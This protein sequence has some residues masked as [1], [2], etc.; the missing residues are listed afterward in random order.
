[1]GRIIS[2]KLIPLYVT[3]LLLGKPL[4]VWQRSRRV[5][6][7]CMSRSCARYQAV[8][9]KVV[10]ETYN[11]GG[12]NEW[13][14]IDV[15]HALCRLVDGEFAAQPAVGAAISECAGGAG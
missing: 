12:N 11:I 8:L 9:Q 13:A 1:M 10:G 5:A 14:N 2:R 7:G 3:N 15:V 6:I 4:P